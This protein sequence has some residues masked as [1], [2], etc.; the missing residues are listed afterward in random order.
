MRSIAFLFSSPSL[1]IHIQMTED[2]YGKL[3]TAVDSLNRPSY[4]DIEGFFDKLSSSER[5]LC[6]FTL[7]RLGKEMAVMN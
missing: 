2:L 1:Y 6:T 7:Y 5:K 3:L 4:S